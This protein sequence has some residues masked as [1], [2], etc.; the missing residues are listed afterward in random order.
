[1]RTLSKYN[2]QPVRF[3]ESTT[4]KDGV[5]CDVYEFVNDKSKD[6]GI[7]NVQKG[8]KTPL[9]LVVG[10]E[11]TLEI[12]QQGQGVLTVVDKNKNK[13]EYSFPSEQSEVEVKVEEKMQWEALEDL[14]FAEICYP[15]YKDGRFRNLNEWI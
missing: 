11:K 8:Y 2:N 7:V 1:M 4:V 15:P 9:Q 6:L 3:I 14:V 10:G 12:F 5:V 13:R